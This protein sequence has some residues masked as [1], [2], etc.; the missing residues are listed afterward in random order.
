MK[1]TLKVGSVLQN[2][3]V[4]Q[5]KS[6]TPEELRMY[7]E[8]VHGPLALVNAAEDLL[9]GKH[10][11]FAI[12]SRE[13]E[14]TGAAPVVKEI[15]EM[16]IPD[17]RKCVRFCGEKGNPVGVGSCTVYGSGSL[18]NKGK[19]EPKDLPLIVAAIACAVARN[20]WYFRV[21]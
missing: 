1:D 14:G 8:D 15:I 21:E 19:Y 10:V 16:A 20:P 13:P 11:A 4:I 5:S 12:C 6:G 2:E 18:D 17:G 7:T 9:A 3:D